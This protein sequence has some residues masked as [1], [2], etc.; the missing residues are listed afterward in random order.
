MRGH[1][2]ERR[3]AVWWEVRQVAKWTKEKNQ[4]EECSSWTWEPQPG[5]AENL[6][7]FLLK[8]RGNLGVCDGPKE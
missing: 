8:F 2:W 4:A 5:K 1:A 6:G 7:K 3:K